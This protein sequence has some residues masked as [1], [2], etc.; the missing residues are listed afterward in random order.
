MSEISFVCILIKKALLEAHSLIRSLISRSVAE[1]DGRR[2]PLHP[3]RLENGSV[4][5]LDTAKWEVKLDWKI[6]QAKEIIDENE[7]QTTISM[8]E[9]RIAERRK[10]FR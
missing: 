6:D 3:K 2:E 7:L 4:R 5:Q 1:C 10:T 9:R 8:L